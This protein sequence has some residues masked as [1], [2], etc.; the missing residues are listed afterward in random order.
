MGL[1]NI[2]QPYPCEIKGCAVYT[3]DGKID[4]EK[5]DCPYKKIKHVIGIFG[6]Y[7]WLRG[8]VYDHMVVEATNGKYTLYS[9]LT[10]DE[11]KEILEA[12]KKNYKPVDELDAEWKNQLIEYLEQLLSDV[13]D[14][15]DFKL[16]AWY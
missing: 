6:T 11:L 13:G 5:T 7:C 16:V 4:C 12:V 2:P 8:K 15:K 10:A 9:D 3:E 14:R 1:D